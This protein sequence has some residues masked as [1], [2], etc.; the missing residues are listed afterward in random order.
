MITGDEKTDKFRKFFLENFPK[1][2][3][4]AWKLLKSEEDAEDIAQDIFV[5]LWAH[6]D[7][8]VER[9]KWDSYLFSMLRNHIYNFL[10]H[11][12]VEAH[13]IESV[14]ENMQVSL[15]DFDE[16]ADK[17]YAKEI[18]ILLKMALEQMPPQRRK[19]FMLSRKQG[20]SNQEIADELNL[21]VRTVEH[22]LYLALREL[23][24]NIL[25]FLIFSLSS[26]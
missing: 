13:Y 8:W 15:S 22:H 16:T 14:T 18:N 1:V 6:P 23:K 24:K 11:K 2:K 19:I 3:A 4:F 25:I 20:L 9:E 26:L 12:S 10:E 7:L 5:K 17:L 21:S